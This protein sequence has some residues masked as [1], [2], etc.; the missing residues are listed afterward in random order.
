MLPSKKI[1]KKK[2]KTTICIF[3]TFLCKNR[4]KEHFLGFLLMDLR[5]FYFMMTICLATGTRLAS[6]AICLATGQ[7][8][9]SLAKRPRRPKIKDP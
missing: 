9:A 2:K 5:I 4:V 1:K 6:L 7:R 3:F 8:L